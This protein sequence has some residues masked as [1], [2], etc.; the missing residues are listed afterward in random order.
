[1]AVAAIAV[2]S[3]LNDEGWA[4][5]QADF[6]AQQEANKVELVTGVGDEAFF[7][8]ASGQLNVLHEKSWLLITYGRGDSVATYTLNDAVKLAQTV[9]NG[10]KY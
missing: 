3:A 10:Q 5:N 9:L 8:P 7:I 1:M 6:A 4:E 2:R